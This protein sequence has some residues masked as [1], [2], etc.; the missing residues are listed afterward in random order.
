MKTI[1]YYFTG[2]GNT[3][4]V[5]RVLAEELGDTKLVPLRQAI[6]FGG[7]TP[8]ADAVGIA[9]PVHFLDM[10]A[11][12]RQFVSGI[13]FTGDPY[14]FGL[15]T[16]GERPGGALFRL[17]ELMEEKRYTLSAGFSVVM[18]EN[19]IAPFNLMGDAARRDEK[20][21]A[22]KRRVAEIAQAVREK[23]VSVPEGNN[24]GL[25]RA[26]G[27]LM[28]RFATEWY[29][30][31]SRFHATAAC[32]RCGT[33]ARICPTRNITVTKD[34]VNWGADCTQCYACIHWCPGGAIEIGGRTKGTPRYHHPDVSL[35]DMLVQRGEPK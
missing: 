22:A 2:T 4:A 5:A 34:G 7:Y 32:N 10:P 1:I 14:I 29:N 21:A 28:R 12:V 11:M 31:P 26:G 16:C 19:Y 6:Y 8:Q 17:Q 13:L 24:S 30:V 3:L 27:N 15:A 33:C 9:F 23:K 35:R 25:L 20:Y 18:P